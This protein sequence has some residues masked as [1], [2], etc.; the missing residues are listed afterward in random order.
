MDSTIVGSSSALR[1]PAFL[2]CSTFMKIVELMILFYLE[3][4]AIFNLHDID[5]SVLIDYYI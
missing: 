4:I 5:F 3:I 1:T 2:R